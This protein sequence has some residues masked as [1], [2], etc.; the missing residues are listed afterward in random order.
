MTFFSA[1][2]DFLNAHNVV[3]RLLEFVLELLLEAV[4]A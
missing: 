2:R 1:L 3:D 4:R